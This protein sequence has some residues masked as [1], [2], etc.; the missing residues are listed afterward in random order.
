MNLGTEKQSKVLRKFDGQ[1][2]KR[3]DLQSKLSTG[4]LVLEVQTH[5]APDLPSQLFAFP[6]S[7]DA[8]VVANELVRGWKY[9]PKVT[10]LGPEQRELISGVDLKKSGNHLGL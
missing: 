4:A 2:I 1:A 6:A 5:W 8:D 10:L 9:L 7:T 3:E